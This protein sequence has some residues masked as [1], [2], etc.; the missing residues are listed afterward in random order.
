[1]SAGATLDYSIASCEQYDVDLQ[2]WTKISFLNQARL[3]HAM[4]VLEGYA[5]C[6]FRKVSLI[7]ADSADIWL[8]MKNVHLFQS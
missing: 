3:F 1:M 2:F 4:V 8:R 6:K 7:D 5:C